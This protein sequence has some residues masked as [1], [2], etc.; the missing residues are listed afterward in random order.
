MY[1]DNKSEN[2]RICSVALRELLGKEFTNLRSLSLCI[3]LWSIQE[4]YIT[5]PL[6]LSTYLDGN[7][8]G[9]KGIKNLTKA[10]LPHL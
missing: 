8:I 5:I 7:K 4:P 3:F 1:M 2:N 6:Y 9:S 10:T